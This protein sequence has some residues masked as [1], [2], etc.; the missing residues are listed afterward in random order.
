[1]LN[2]DGSIG[3]GGGQVLRTS[4]ALA[5]ITSKAFRMTNIRRRRAKPGLMPQHLKA[6]EAARAVAMAHV[7][8]D[9]LG[10]QELVFE[11]TGLGA[12]RFHCDIGTAGSVSLLLET[13]VYPLSFGK[14]DSHVTLVGGTHVPWSPS[15]HYLKLH[16]LHY[17][18]KIGLDVQLELES[19]GFYPRG[20]GC[21]RA[22]VRPVTKLF[23]LDLTKRGSLRRIQGISAVANLS[24][25]IAE[26]QKREALRKLG[27]LAS[28]A[29]FDVLS[30]RALSPGTFL[31]LLAEFETS[32]CCFCAL[33][34]RGKPA[35]R[36]ADEAVNELREFLSTDGTVDHYLADQLVVPLALAAGESEVRTSRITEHLTTNAEVVE[37][38]LP[39]LIAVDGRLGE[40]GSL[41][42]G[43]NT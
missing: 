40:P 2:I 8:G 26:R 33:G 7:L 4:L 35:E 28:L 31:L 27:E 11:P 43:P 39:V 21:V 23:P 30:M 24:Q 29:E 19:A 14:V 9:R 22:T 6:V 5:A 20:G 18:E 10:S 16:W 37:M 42:I 13:V 1:M 17:I 38:F 41:K 36:V 25:Q 12:G 32:Q 3:E 34:A 15:F